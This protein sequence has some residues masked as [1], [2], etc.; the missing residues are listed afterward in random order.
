MYEFLY[1][2]H[3]I[4]LRSADQLP[5]PGCPCYK[6]FPKASAAIDKSTVQKDILIQS[7]DNKTWCFWCNFLP[8][9][10]TTL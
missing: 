4:T 5:L 6:T 8:Q 1:M 9:A 10:K 7:G 2:H 3:L